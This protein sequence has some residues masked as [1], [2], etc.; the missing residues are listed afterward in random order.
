MLEGLLQ[1]FLFAVVARL[2]WGFGG[3]LVFVYNW[4]VWKI[5]PNKIASQLTI[6]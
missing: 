2:G 3:K 5:L 1:I 4:T 6:N